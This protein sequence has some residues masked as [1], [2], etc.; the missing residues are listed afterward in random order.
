MSTDGRGAHPNSGA[1]AS[2]IKASNDPAT[3]GTTWPGK[4]LGVDPEVTDPE[5]QAGFGPDDIAPGDTINALFVLGVKGLD[6]PYAGMIGRQWLAGE[7]TDEQKDALVNSTIDS[8]FDVMRQAKDVYETAQFDD[9][10]SGMRYASSRAEFEQSLWDAIDADKLALSPPAPATFSVESAPSSVVLNWT[11]NTTTGSDIAGWHVYRAEASM[12]GDSAF[13]LIH[14]APPGEFSYH[15]GNVEV[16]FSYYYYLTTFDSDGNEST[17][18]TRTS[19]PAIPTTGVA[20]RGGGPLKFELSQNAPNPFN[21]ST[22][23][24]LSLSEAGDTQFDIYSVN[25]QLVRSLINGHMAA[26]HHEVVWDGLDSSGKQVASGAYIYRLV[27]G[28]NVQ[29]RRMVLVR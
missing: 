24:S 23:I 25:G 13:T 16:G 22:T 14:T 8:L 12:K 18:H 17:M 29:V 4:V 19:D 10:H 15:D 7:I 28:E 1:F 21:P 3:S 9:G 27:S 2:W 11:L 6:E 26:G 5:Q 20:I